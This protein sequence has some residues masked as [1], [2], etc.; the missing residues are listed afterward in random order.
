MVLTKNNTTTITPILLLLFNII[1]LLF[2]DSFNLDRIVNLSI[3]IVALIFIF[4]LRNKNIYLFYTMVGFAITAF[5]DQANFSG[6]IFIFMSIYDHKTK[7]NL[8]INIIALISALC[9]Q[10]YIIKYLDAHIF[11]MLIA[12]FFV[13]SHMYIRFWSVVKLKESELHKQGLTVE[14]IQ[15]I[16]CLEKGYKHQKAARILHI[17]R[18]TYSARVSSLRHRY[19][20]DTDFQ[21]GKKLSEDSMLSSNSLAKAKTEE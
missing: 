13:F 21:L 3:P 12:F 8:I 1:M 20:V 9:L 5:G 19:G 6:A 10:T 17:E 11:S 2:D 16:D 18:K 15:T 4:I 7:N 14:Q